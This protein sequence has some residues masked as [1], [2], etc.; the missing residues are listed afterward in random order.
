MSR[1]TSPTFGPM[2]H[3]QDW[4]TVVIRKKNEGKKDGTAQGAP[5]STASVSTGQRKNQG[6]PAWK[7]EKRVDGES[8]KV[9]DTVGKETGAE[10]TRARLA[11]KWTQK[12][13]AVT[14]NMQEKYIN[15]IERGVAV[16]NGPD[17]AKIR[18]VLG[19]VSR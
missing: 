12:Q 14:V 13:L 8:G 6:T 9:I 2:N 18:R 4:E 11:K 19:L 5:K 16:R 7:I 15:E 17:L 1:T 10:I 3:H